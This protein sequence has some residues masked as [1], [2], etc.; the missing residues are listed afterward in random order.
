VPSDALGAL[1]IARELATVRTPASSLDKIVLELYE[2]ATLR[3]TR[4]SAAAGRRQR[5]RLIR[6]FR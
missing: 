2:G 5:T 3:S 6:G 4:F 1:E